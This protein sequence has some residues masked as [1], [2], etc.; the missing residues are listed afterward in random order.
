MMH[1]RIGLQS[2]DAVQR[3]H[4]EEEYSKLL[5]SQLPGDAFERRSGSIY[6]IILAFCYSM[7][8]NL[9]VN[10]T[11]NFVVNLGADVVKYRHY[12]QPYYR[13]CISKSKSG[14]RQKLLPEVDAPLRAQLT[15]TATS[16][17]GERYKYTLLSTSTYYVYLSRSCALSVPT[18]HSRIATNQPSARRSIA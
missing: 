4:V 12:F 7:E 2:I 1:L 14:D 16:G 10:H 18:T 6:F 3:N 9:Y 11:R 17:V 8:R 15:L 5:P 13:L